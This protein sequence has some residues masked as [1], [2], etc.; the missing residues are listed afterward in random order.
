MN[1]D[2][3]EIADLQVEVAALLSDHVYAPLLEDQH[4]RGVLPA[5]S[6]A[7]TV[8]AVLGDRGETRPERLTAY[9]IPSGTARTCARRTTSSHC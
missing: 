2:E 1:E 7:P 9:E 3:R 4:V 6:Q 8:R 5:P